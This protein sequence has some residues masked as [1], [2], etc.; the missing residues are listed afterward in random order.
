MELKCRGIRGQTVQSTLPNAQLSQ[1]EISRRRS[2]C[3]MRKE[4]CGGMPIVTGREPPFTAPSR[5]FRPQKPVIL[6]IRL[7]ETKQLYSVGEMKSFFF[8]FLAIIFLFL[9]TALIFLVVC[10]GGGSLMVQ[11]KCDG[12]VGRITRDRR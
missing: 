9:M 4:R 3:P 8:I 1:V 6:S 2:I 5:F 12:C 7:M 10:G 11:T